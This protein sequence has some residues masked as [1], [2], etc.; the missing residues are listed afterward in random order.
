MRLRRYLLGAAGAIVLLTAAI[1]PIQPASA[2]CTS[3]SVSDAQ[4][5]IEPDTGTTMMT[6]TVS[7]DACAGSNTVDYSTVDGTAIAGEDYTE[8]SGTLTFESP[9][10]PQEVEVPIVGDTVREWTEDLTLEITSTDAPPADDEGFG[11]ILDNDG[12]T[13]VLLF[14]ND[15]Y[16]DID[17]TSTGNSEGNNTKAALEALGHDVTTTEAI[18]SAG[19]S[20]AL[21]GNDVFVIPEQEEGPIAPDLDADAQQAIVD[22]V[23]G[24]GSLVIMDDYADF[25]NTVF[26]YSLVDENADDSEQTAAAATTE[27]ATD[28]PMLDDPSA[29]RGATTASLPAGA[30][31][32]YLDAGDLASVFVTP[33][34]DGSVVWLGYDW[35]NSVPGFDAS[36][37]LNDDG[38]V[39]SYEWAG[40]LDSAV[41]LPSLAIDDVTVTESDSEETATFTVTLDRAVSEVVMVDFAT[42]T[43]SAGSDDFTATSGTL[44]FARGETS[45]T[46][47]VAITGDELHE[48]TETF[49]VALSD[50]L[51]AT[52]TE[53]TG[54]GT[55]IDDDTADGYRMVAGDGGIFTFGERN[56]HG[57]TGDLVLNQP[58]VG[59]A[60]RGGD[61]DGYWIVARDGGVFAFNA[62][63]HGS[64]ANEVLS[65]PAVDIEPTP[66]GKG[67][68]V[69]L[70]DGTVRAFGDA[71]HVGDM[72]GVA[73]NA[74]IIGISSTI[75]GMGYWL[76]AEDGGIFSFGDAVFHGSMGGQ[77]LNSP[78]IDLGPTTDGGGYYLLGGDGGVFS[79]GTAVFYGSTGAMQLN[80]PVVGMLVRSDGYWF[81][82]SDGGVFTFGGLPFLG[83]MGGVPLNSP[84]LEMM[85]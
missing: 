75:S 85:D 38:Q 47:D 8:V 5:V 3:S 16:I 65:A 18:D 20:T 60:T 2:A 40:I 69:V 44:T 17:D 73:L 42:A 71:T 79:F 81:A 13:P 33:E 56:F 82:A 48:D 34:G 76:V 58:I 77:Q 49:T 72:A 66:T 7:V 29:T 39:S 11:Q 62:E 21:E 80:E 51:N 30:S 36:D 59:G 57:S 9:W 32:I 55:I 46:I 31:T 50:P 41:E 43:G 68:W 22:F 24:G 54:T 28:A 70:E 27:F 14:Y 78:V 4:P 19:L 35:F 23:E 63:F 12:A 61:F 26:G 83:S 53:G 10:D 64:L 15:A 45:K 84:V 37:S 52:I 67:Y 1:F 6:F 74:P 25:V